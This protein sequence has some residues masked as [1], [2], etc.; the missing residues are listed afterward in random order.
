M[1]LSPL[2]RGGKHGL[3][4]VKAA[5][6]Q[7][8]SWNWSDL[9]CLRASLPRKSPTTGDNARKAAALRLVR[10]GELSRASRILTRNG[11]APSTEDTARKLISKHPPRSSALPP[12]PNVSCESITLFRSLLFDSIRQAPHGSGAGPSS[13]RFEHFEILLENEDTADGLFSAC[14]AFAKGILPNVAATLFS[15]SRL[16]ALP[17][18]NGDVR[19]IAIGGNLFADLQPGLFVHKKGRVY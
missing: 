13:W 1:L 16:I 2:A 17:K 9:I 10:C 18:P 3:R 15:S 11:L 14:S 4:D 12:P 19:P 5:Y 8:L 6:H 7:F